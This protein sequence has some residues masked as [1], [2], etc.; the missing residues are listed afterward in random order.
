[1]V[2]ALAVAEPAN[3]ADRKTKELLHDFNGNR[4]VQF[5][6]SVACRSSL[7]HRTVKKTALVPRAICTKI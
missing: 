2:D 3:V 7:R 5:L 6:A 4:H 1:M